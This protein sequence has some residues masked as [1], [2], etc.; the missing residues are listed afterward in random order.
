MITT[1]PVNITVNRNEAGLVF[2]TVTI[3]LSDE[4]FTYQWQRNGS[5][6]MESPGKFGGVKTSMLTIIDAQNEDENSYQCVIYNGAGDGVRSNKAF[7]SVGKPSFKVYL[8]FRLILKWNLS[9]F[10]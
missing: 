7:L 3:Q 6:L 4:E 5:D 10:S 1:E 8:Y 2:F 9:E